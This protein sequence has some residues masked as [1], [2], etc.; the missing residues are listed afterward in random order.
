MVLWDPTRKVF[1]EKK[2]KRLVL[3][4]PY[5]LQPVAGSCTPLSDIGLAASEA[6]NIALYGAVFEQAIQA[7][8]T[9]KHKPHQH[10]IH[11]NLPTFRTAC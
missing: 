4:S 2:S 7:N 1:Y 3:P 10:K 9:G 8:H 5:D 11:V 6:G